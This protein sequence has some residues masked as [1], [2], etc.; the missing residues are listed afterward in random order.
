MKGNSVNSVVNSKVP[1]LRFYLKKRKKNG[2][3][4][5]DILYN[6]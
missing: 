4:D 6:I 3:M 5:F 1:F 2:M